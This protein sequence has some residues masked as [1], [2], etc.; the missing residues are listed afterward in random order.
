M[1]K[2][3]V[4]AA[5]AAAVVALAVW[6]W[7]PGSWW[8]CAL[9]GVLAAAAALFVVFLYLF[10]YP[11]LQGLVSFLRHTCYSVRIKGLEN[12]P[13]S[14]PVIL[15]ANHIS[16]L[17]ALI[18]MGLTRRRIRFLMRT[19]FYNM[20]PFHW[21][22]RRLGVIEVPENTPKLMIEFL[23]KVRARLQDG[24]V[25][26]VFPEGGVSGNGLILRFKKGISRMIPPGLTVPVL[27]VRLGMVWGSLFLPYN[28]KFRFIMPRQFPMPLLVSIGSPLPTLQITAFQLRQRISELG[29]EMEMERFP[30]EHPI[31][32]TFTHLA[33]LRPL[34][35]AFKEF[36]GAGVNNF[37]MLVRGLIFS[38]LIRSRLSADSRYVGVLLPNCNA[39]ATALFGILFADRTP[40]VLNFTAGDAARQH[41]INKAK[42][43]LILTSRLFLK[44]LRIEPTPEMVFLEDLA[45]EVTPALK[46]K[47]MLA[48]A[49]LPTRMLVRRFAPESWDDV[50]R[51]AV[52]LFSS[53]S[54]G[55][56]KGIQL[57]HHNIIADFFSFWRIINWTPRDRICGNLPLFHAFGFMTGFALPALSDTRVIYISN[58]LDAAGVCELVEKEKPTILVAT[59]TFMQHYMRKYKPGQF[60]SLR[61]AVTGAEKLRKDINEKFQE[62]TGL[63]LVEGFGCTEL[64]PIVAINLAHSIFNLG[65]EFGVPGS[66]GAPL[67]GIHVKIA[68]P[69]TGEELPAGTPGLMMVKGGLVMKGYLDEPEAT[70]A[71]LKDGYFC[72][73][74][75]ASM[76]EDG[77]L[78]ITGRLARFSKIAGEMVPHE[79]VE[80]AIN[81]VLAAEER[82]VGV[83]GAKDEKRG[84]RLVVF[85]ATDALDPEK[86]VEEL[87]KKELPNLW[88]PKVSDFVKIEKIPML[89]TGKLDVQ[90]LQKMA[91]ELKA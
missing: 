81:E 72:T 8:F 84:E 41:A 27:P 32:Y 44:K 37:S 54:T 1:G 53:G 47:C 83:C 11:M 59:P 31:H 36:N 68:D 80:M 55:V 12:I 16:F 91:N 39:A 20:R 38:K 6:G 67:P 79:L 40:A 33:K 30:G 23:R 71:C 10:P 35:I 56:P 82:C 70:A 65:R 3:G 77:Y 50:S 86:M 76:R 18:L 75:I 14:G 7:W 17:D 69:D 88:L 21:V 28:G 78:T 43:R 25:V 15:A 22:F 87:K 26:C 19:Q 34:G 60:K 57:S 4:T 62:Q 90:G 42:M 74:D 29:A 58:P 45:K 61:L 48:A 66:I 64:S 2:L 5:I 13:E 89:A 63:K 49:L 46:W 73:G 52:L 24:E 9:L 85:Y 51:D